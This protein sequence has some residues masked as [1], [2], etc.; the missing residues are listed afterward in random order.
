MFT[1]ALVTAL[2]PGNPTPNVTCG[3]LSAADSTGRRKSRSLHAHMGSGGDQEEE[4]GQGAGNE[5]DDILTSG[6]GAGGDGYIGTATTDVRIR[7]QGGRAV[8]QAA[9]QPCTESV[10]VATFTLPPTASTAGL[11]QNITATSVPSPAGEEG[12]GVGRGRWRE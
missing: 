11:V 6:I 9:L 7:V 12:G 2:G 1:A 8:L 3:P 4:E 10:L 5:D